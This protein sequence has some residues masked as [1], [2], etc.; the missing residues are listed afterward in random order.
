MQCNT[1]F[2]I[3]VLQMFKDATNGKDSKRRI[4]HSFM[5]ALDPEGCLD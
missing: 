5:K 3:D 2:K 1:G 4:M